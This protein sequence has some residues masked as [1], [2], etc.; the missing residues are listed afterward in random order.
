VVKLVFGRNLSDDS[1][2]L[3]KASKSNILR[4]KGIGYANQ[5]AAIVSLPAVDRPTANRVANE[6]FGLHTRKTIS[7]LKLFNAGTFRK[8]LGKF[9][10]RP[11]PR[12]SKD[13]PL[14][15][16]LHMRCSVRPQY[17]ADLCCTGA[18]GEMFKPVSC[19]FRCSFCGSP[20]QVA[21]IKMV[22][23]LTWNTLLC[24]N[25]LCRRKASAPKWLC[26][27]GLRWQSCP[28]HGPIGFRC[29]LSKPGDSR[30]QRPALTSHPA[31]PAGPVRAGSSHP[32]LKRKSGACTSALPPSGK[33]R[34]PGTAVSWFPD[35]PSKLPA[36]LKA[37]FA[38]L[39]GGPPNQAPEFQDPHASRS[40]ASPRQPN[41]S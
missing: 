32:E 24:A 16:T 25:A 39:D 2:H 31:L 20:K 4:L 21:H 19:I 33:R 34:A 23:G 22:K 18:A 9:S 13:T 8:A 36:K 38:Y 35:L 1:K 29:G 30:A 6:L 3:C 37:R 10:Y 15:P 26:T 7:N 17:Y 5:V 11:I 41:P 40:T 28:S 27:C 14:L 12:W